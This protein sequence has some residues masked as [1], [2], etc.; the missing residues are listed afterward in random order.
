MSGRRMKLREPDSPKVMLSHGSLN[1]RQCLLTLHPLL[2]PHNYATSSASLALT[3]MPMS[4]PCCCTHVAFGQFRPHVTPW[5]KAVATFQ[6]LTTVF[7]FD[8]DSWFLSKVQKTRAALNSQ[9]QRKKDHRPKQGKAKLPQ[10]SFNNSFKVTLSKPRGG[11]QR[12]SLAS[13]SILV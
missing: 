5:S 9:S 11:G 10:V 4:A 6:Q 1:S 12:D 13:K 3:R 8:H 7:R 2:S